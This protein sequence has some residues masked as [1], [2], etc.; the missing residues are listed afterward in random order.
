MAKLKIV[1]AQEIK[2]DPLAGGTTRP[3]LALADDGNWYVLKLFK[4]RHANQRCYTGAEVFAH[5]LANECSLNVPEA[6]FVKIPNNLLD[7]LEKV[8]PEQ[9]QDIIARDYKRV[10]FASRYLDKLATFSPA[11]AKKYIEAGDLETIFAFDSL[12]LNEDRKF[13]KPNILRN[14]SNWWLIDHEKAFEGIKYAKSLYLNNSLCPF[15][16]NHLFFKILKKRVKAEGTGKIFESFEYLFSIV[17]LFG[18]NEILIQLNQLGYDTTECEL[19][20]QYL[21]DIKRN[22]PDFIKIL[23]SS[24]K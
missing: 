6:V 13:R 17:S 4:Q 9:Y 12:I 15:S 24:L 22:L 14:K 8:A 19:W 3:L 10:C 16:K 5:Y 1:N 21:T 18:L 7:L 11:L 23:R 2:A 20:L